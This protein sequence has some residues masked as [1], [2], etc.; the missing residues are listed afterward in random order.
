MTSTPLQG[1]PL[2][3]PSHAPLHA[4]VQNAALALAAD[5]TLFTEVMRRGSMSAE[6]YQPQG[7]DH[8]QPHTQDELYVVISGHGDFINGDTR[9]PF[10]P[11]DLIM[12]PAGVAHRFVDFSA[13]FCTWVVF[14]GPQGGE[15]PDR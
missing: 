3:A 7:H 15:P 13:D 10:G 5:K 14:Y 9:H 12:V 1:A 2:H 6:L 11:G 4:T 8:Q